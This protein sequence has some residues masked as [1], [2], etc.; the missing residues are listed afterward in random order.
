MRTLQ[1]ARGRLIALV[2]ITAVSVISLLVAAAVAG[3]P[4]GRDPWRDTAILLGA[5]VAA[6]GCLYAA[7]EGGGRNWVL[8]HAMLKDGA[9]V[10]PLPEASGAGLL[11]LARQLIWPLG[12][13]RVRTRTTTP[14][15]EQA[16]AVPGK[17]SRGWVVRAAF[18]ANH[19]FR[20]SADRDPRPRIRYWRTSLSGFWGE[21]FL[22]TMAITVCVIIVWQCEKGNLIDCLRLYPLW[23]G[24]VVFIA[25]FAIAD[26]CVRQ[27]DAARA[28]GMS[29]AYV[30]RTAAAYSAYGL[31]SWL[32]FA[33]GTVL[34]AV[35]AQEFFAF[36]AAFEAKVRAVEAQLAALK[37]YVGGVGLAKSPEAAG[38][39]AERGMALLER[40]YGGVAE[41]NFELQKQLNPIFLFAGLLVMLNILITHT[42]L[43]SLFMNDARTL[44]MIFTYVPLT[45]VGLIGFYVYK[46]SYESLLL[47][48]ANEMRWMKFPHFAM[49]P[50]LVKREL[51]ILNTVN[52]ANNI[53]GFAAAVG[54]SSSGAAVF[55]WLLKEVLDRTSGKD[56]DLDVRLLHRPSHRFRPQEPTFK[57]RD[58]SRKYVPNRPPRRPQSRR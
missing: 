52:S 43:R 22:A 27:V 21:A 34:F 57:A 41:A 58:S 8:R 44:T 49:A 51:E 36:A 28:N 15:A 17:S 29:A 4:G 25:A 47:T 37:P 23:V 45:L 33:F 18:I 56:G 31:Y 55:I 2:A 10:W 9:R 48:F 30:E 7:Y 20:A 5:Y 11:H 1:L 38:V 19:N 39:L 46:S 12:V 14:G 6:L 53:F 32:L 50:E 24:I 3:M 42:R 16:P 40:A 35:L 13:H 54:G 26:Y